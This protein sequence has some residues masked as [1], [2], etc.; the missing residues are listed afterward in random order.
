M[1]TYLNETPQNAFFKYSSRYGAYA[2][3]ILVFF[4][5]IIYSFEVNV[6]NPI[7]A[8]L[9]FVVTFGVTIVF[10]SFGA[11]KYRTEALFGNLTF[12]QAALFTFVI[13]II[14]FYISA[15]FNFILNAWIDPAYQM[16]QFD[17]LELY[18]YSM[19]EK[20]SLLTDESI[21]DT[22]AKSKEN[23]INPYKQFLASLY[24]SPLYAGI[25]ALL[26]SIF[27]KRKVNT[28]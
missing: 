28:I 22:L 5:V 19:Q 1:E 23:L 25:M 27:V 6:F 18:L 11:K 17:K 20:Y 2:G 14:A 4:A 21:E 7:L 10:M 13:G 24:T 15:L 12:W 26:V 3:L 9:S 8:L 16:E